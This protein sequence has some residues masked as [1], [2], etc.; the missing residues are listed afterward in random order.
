MPCEVLGSLSG[1]GNSQSRLGGATVT[2]IQ[3]LPTGSSGTERP[4]DLQDSHGTVGRP[5]GEF[6]TK[7]RRVSQSPEHANGVKRVTHSSHF[8]LEERQETLVQDDNSTSSAKKEGLDDHF[9]ADPFITFQVLAE[10]F[11]INSRITDTHND[12][13]RL[14]LVT[15]I[16]K[17][18]KKSLADQSRKE[19]GI[20]PRQPPTPDFRDLALGKL[21]VVKCPEQCSFCQ[22]ECFFGTLKEDVLLLASETSHCCDECRNPLAFRDE[23]EFLAEASQAFYERY[24]TDTENFDMGPRAES[25]EIPSEDSAVSEGSAIAPTQ[26][27]PHTIHPTHEIITEHLERISEESNQPD[28]SKKFQIRK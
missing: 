11:H 28:H 13:R 1:L 19:T 15:T 12:V 4:L 3:Q 20:L 10:E 5:T 27:Y 21:A 7:S 6:Q 24:S 26:S 8:Q 14:E 18:V 16:H 22:F 25:L 2:V 23:Y 17:R 9:V